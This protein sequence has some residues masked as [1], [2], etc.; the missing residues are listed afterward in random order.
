GAALTGPPVRSSASWRPTRTACSLRDDALALARGSMLPLLEEMISALTIPFP[1]GPCARSPSAP[2]PPR[3]TRRT[4]G[5]PSFRTFDLAH[6]SP[7][8]E[9]A[10]PP[11]APPPCGGPS[12]A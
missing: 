6:R 5:R 1:P 11:A 9:G 3:P 7:A 2:R 12:P 4:L 10:C 8:Q